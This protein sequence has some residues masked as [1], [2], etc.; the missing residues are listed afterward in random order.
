MPDSNGQPLPPLPEEAFD[1]H[2]EEAAIHKTEP[3]PKTCNHKD[4]QI[5][6]GTEIR[7]GC[8]A[9]WTGASIMMIYNALKN[10]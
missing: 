1:G 10:Q 5:I 2:K 6:S 3:L 7:C 9:G 4:V 8:G